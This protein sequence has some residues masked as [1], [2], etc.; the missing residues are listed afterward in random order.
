M[1]NGALYY[2]KRSIYLSNGTY[3]SISEYFNI[4][5]STVSSIKNGKNYTKITEKIREENNNGL[6]NL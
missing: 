6:N 4:S 5:I 3:K 1:N 2:K